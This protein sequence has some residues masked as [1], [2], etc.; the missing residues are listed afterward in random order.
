MMG[1]MSELTLSRAS[2]SVN[3]AAVVI[4]T[5][6]KMRDRAAMCHSELTMAQFLRVKVSL[7]PYASVVIMMMMSKGIRIEDIATARCIQRRLVFADAGMGGLT[8]ANAVAVLIVGL[9]RGG[10]Q[11]VNSDGRGRS[12]VLNS[13]R[14]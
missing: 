2:S 6:W 3:R 14:C 1:P 12:T 8:V 13:R 10:E 7:S 9:K 5:L 11:E 4:L